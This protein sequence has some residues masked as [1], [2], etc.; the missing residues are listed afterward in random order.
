MG[1]RLRKVGRDLLARRTQSLLVILSIGI[2]VMG[3]VTLFTMADII[4]GNMEGSMDNRRLAMVYAY[5]SPK[6]EGLPDD[7]AMLSA[8]QAIPEVTDVQGLALFPMYWRQADNQTIQV[9]RLLGYADFENIPLEPPT[10]IEGRF[11]IAGAKELAIERRFARYFAVERGDTL[12]MQVPTESG[13]REEAWTVVGILYQPYPYATLPGTPSVIPGELMAFAHYAEVEYLTGIRGYR[14]FMVRFTDFAA[15]EGGFPAVKTAIAD[16]ESPYQSLTSLLEDPAETSS[17]RRILIFRDVLTFLAVL[18]LVVSGFLVLNVMNTMVVE[19]RRQIGVMRALGATN[20]DYFLMY[21]GMAL[22]YGV[23]GVI[24]GILIGIPAGYIASVQ[25]A[26]EINL[27]LDGF[28]WSPRAVVLGIGLGIVVPLAAAFVPI[29][30]GIR[31]TILEAMTD[32]GI[33]ARYVRGFWGR[34]IDA[35]PA[36]PNIRMAL[37]NVTLRKGRLFLTMTMLSL[38]AGSF[39][40]IFALLTSFNNLVDNVFSTFGMQISVNPNGAADYERIYAILDTEIAGID[41]IAPGTTLSIDI[42][43]YT[44]QTFPATPSFLFAFGFDPETPEVMTLQLSEGEMPRPFPK[45][46]VIISAGIARR[47]QK[48]VGDEI[49]IKVGDNA[50]SLRIVGVATYS[51]DTVWLHWETLSILGGLVEGL[52]APNTYLTTLSI[53]AQTTAVA[54]IDRQA[55]A[56]LEFVAGEMSVAGRRQLLLSETLAAAQGLGLGDAVMVEGE[57]YTVVGIFNLNPLLAA[58]IEAP[59]ALALIYWEEVLA[60]QGL[61]PKGKPRPNAI[62]VILHDQDADGFAVAQ[63][64][65]EI[66]GVMLKNGINATYTNWVASWEVLTQ[67]LLTAGIVLNVAAGL[68]GAV[69]GVGLLSSLSMSVFERQKEIGVMRS[70]GASSGRIAILFLLEGWL[71]GFGAWL[72]GVPISYWLNGVL[73]GLFEFRGVA[74]TEYP[75]SALIVGFIAMMGIA[76]A[77]SLFPAL[78]AARKTVSAVLRYQ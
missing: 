53:N 54:G 48:G 70:V 4:I 58:Q 55:E 52:P 24:P 28:E 20:L 78:A 71:I 14:M 72:I 43:G 31:V 44:P 6:T 63:K 37:R 38:A 32:F 41:Q 19:Q 46:G 61:N 40:G 60:F 36:P 1:T 62:E 22:V 57:A 26:Q 15:A 50:E 49:V 3:V 35:L 65:N 2:G 42:E 39:M 76:T 33:N 66:S 5:V 30:L 34:W 9:G 56:G 18:S 74:G 13:T 68:L 17:M 77:A 45:D 64:T 69:G 51:F 27:Y 7:A 67:L 29:M 16:P 25:V 12:I 10:L 11:P 47:M 8:L 75:V 23:L 73:L 59:P 21:G